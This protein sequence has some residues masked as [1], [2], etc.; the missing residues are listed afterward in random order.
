VHTRTHAVLAVSAVLIAGGLGGCESGV[1]KGVLSLSPQTLENRQLQTRRFDSADELMLIA[2]CAGLLQDLGYSIDS[3]ESKLGLLV[4]SKD[5]DATDAGQIVGAVA[6]AVVFGV[7]TAVDR[8][9]KIRASVVTFSSGGQTA[10]RVTF[11]RV[12]W[13]TDN[14]VSRLEFISDA[15]IYRDFF[16]RL[17]KSVF[18]EAHHI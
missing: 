4:A 14:Q 10:V 5:R 1:P 11:Q 7:R 17:S 16:E 8:N 15:D 12:V 3:S 13:N 9:Q 2:A 18:L 6:I